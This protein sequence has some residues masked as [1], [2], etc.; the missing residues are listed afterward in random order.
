VNDKT[1]TR[2]SIAKETAFN[3]C[4]N[5]I[6]R[7]QF[8]KLVDKWHS[9]FIRYGFKKGSRIAIY[10]EQTLEHFS[11]FVAIAEAGMVYCG[12]QQHLFNDVDASFD[13]VASGISAV[14][15]GADLN[16]RQPCFWQIQRIDTAIVHHELGATE[17]HPVC[18]PDD[19]LIASMT[20][21]STGIPK[22]FFQTHQS[23]MTAAAL[24]VGLFYKPGQRALMY[25]SFNHV[26]VVSVS[27]LPTMMAGCYIISNSIDNHNI[28]NLLET[29]RPE[30]CLIFPYTIDYLKAD[31]RWITH[32]LD[33]VSDVISGGTSIP[34]E[35][36][37][38]LL[39]KGIKK[40]HNVYGLSEALPPLFVQTIERENIENV[41]NENGQSLMGQCMPGCEYKVVDNTL[42]VKSQS[43]AIGDWVLNKTF[44][45]GFISTS[46][47]VQV[48]D[49]KIYYVGRQDKMS[50][51]YDMLI[52][53]SK[54]EQDAKKFVPDIGAC[55]ATVKND[56]VYIGIG[57]FNSETVSQLSIH[58]P[59]MRITNLK[60]LSGLDQ[61]KP[62]NVI[63]G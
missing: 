38:S 13:P 20:S 41:F 34:K 18:Q 6:D 44:E 46:D 53:L 15:I 48:R 36:A 37:I 49:D 54:I 9:L 31:S 21:G 56:Q 1:F 4:G 63:K 5:E 51:Q 24:S 19:Y 61:I 60:E 33:F 50:R 47:I 10:D 29:H 52:N 7:D 62:I 28:W 2:Y 43:V 40:L 55:L 30:I 39:D 8:I 16:N 42:R 25:S 11:A 32:R 45:D 27:M 17:Y 59:G 14:L 22:N 58:Y 3:F 26:G 57:N 12:L 35:F 23:L